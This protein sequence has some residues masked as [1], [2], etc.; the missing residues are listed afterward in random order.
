MVM[1]TCVNVKI[2]RVGPK[3]V[4]LTITGCMIPCNL[5][6]ALVEPE[7]ESLSFSEHTLFSVKSY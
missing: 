6:L 7:E 4:A 5:E 3:R 1:R 2:L